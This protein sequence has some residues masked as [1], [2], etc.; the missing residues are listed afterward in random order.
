[1]ATGPLIISNGL[2]TT[3][4][5]LPISGGGTNNGSLPVTA[6]GVIYTDGSE[7]QNVGVGSSTQVLTS[8]G[9]SP[10]SWQSVASSPTGSYASAYFSIASYWST[11][12]TGY[13][14]GTNTGGNS[15]T[16][17]QSSGITLTAAASNV[18]GITFTPA[19]VSAVYL[20]TAVALFASS[21]AA[22]YGVQY[23]LTDGTTVISSPGNYFGSTAASNSTKCFAHDRSIR[24]RNYFSCYC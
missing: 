16:V 2:P 14:D 11:T 21:G 8:N 15:L 3:N 10:P 1:M 20:I 7:L 22:D 9:S 18:A 13:N 5:P 23:R 6:G 19:N 17:T 4:S 12:N 24:T